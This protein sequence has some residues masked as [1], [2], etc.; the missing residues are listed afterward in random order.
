MNLLATYRRNSLLG[1][2]TT[3]VARPVSGRHSGSSP[4]RSSRVEGW[5]VQHSPSAFTKQEAVR[6]GKVI[7]LA[8]HNHTVL[9]QQRQRLLLK[10]YQDSETP[11]FVV[12]Q[13]PSSQQ[14]VVMHTFEEAE[15]NADLICFI[16]DE[17]HAF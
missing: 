15:I 3:A 17:V 11:H 8:Q 12:C 4:A 2:L 6:V 5:L 9:K 13:N 10:G 16:E 7:V 14:I 1:F